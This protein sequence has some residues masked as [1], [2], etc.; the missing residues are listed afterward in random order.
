MLRSNEGGLTLCYMLRRFSSNIQEPYRTLSL[1]AIDASIQWCQGKS[2]PRASALRAPWA[3]SP[4]LVKQL[5]QFLRRWHLQ[6]LSHQVPC[7]SPSFKVI[8]VK[9]ASVV[10]ILCS[11]KQAVA[12]WASGMTPVCCCKNWA[13]FK[14]ACLNPN[15]EHWILAG[16]LLGGLLPPEQAVIARYSHQE[17]LS[18]H[19]DAGPSTMD[20]TQWASVHSQTRHSVLSFASDL[21][22]QHCESLSTHITKST[23]AARSKSLEGVVFLCEDKQASSLRMFCPYLCYK[24]LENTFLNNKVFESLKPLPSTW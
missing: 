13:A 14:N 19:D 8:F 11:H 6:V 21:W 4:D 3:L 1:Q 18:C 24:S 2:A 7:H 12:D 5:R 17:G 9:H 15:A 20:P 16:N 22:T 23:I 10:D